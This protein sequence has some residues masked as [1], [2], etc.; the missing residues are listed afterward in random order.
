MAV[1]Q[2]LLDSQAGPLPLTGKF[3]PDGDLVPSI[4]LCGTEQS[5]APGQ[6]LAVQLSIVDSAG[7]DAGGTSAIVFSNEAKQHKT[8]LALLVNQKPFAFGETYTWS[9]ALATTATV[10]DAKD[11]FSLMIMY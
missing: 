7:K 5:N 2:V 10:T 1:I 4:Y 9:L 11:F 6:P 8:L 3:Q